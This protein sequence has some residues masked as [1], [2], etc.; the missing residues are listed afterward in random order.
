VLLA[1]AGAVMSLRRPTP[2]PV[3]PAAPPLVAAAAQPALADL[4]GQK[5][6]AAIAAATK[7]NRPQS[8]ITALTAAKT[9]MVAL[10][11]PMKPG[12]PADAAALEQ[13]NGAARQIFHDE[14]APLVRAEKRL[15]GS[16]STP[17]DTQAAPAAAQ[18]LASFT[19]A[20]TNLD[21]ALAVDES[22]AD[23]AHAIDATAQALASFGALQDAYAVA[24]P[25]Y[26][27]AKRKQF[28]AL[29]A[30]AQATAGQVA[31]LANVSKPWILASR[32]RK[33]AYQTRQDN[34][35]KAKSL[36]APLDTLA[37]TL[38]KIS[39]LKQ[40]DAAIAQVTAAKKSLDGLVAASNAATL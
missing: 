27:G 39:D 35:A 24:A 31:T 13:L 15:A 34:A 32:A 16:L 14:S 25:Y 28:A 36:M 8:E 18:S 21:T 26:V 12:K 33:N 29:Y 2:A 3:A 11:A 4:L 20:K 30:D 1:G 22:K 19:Q 38:A 17:L 9:S 37:P 5:L 10:A 6:D 23:A 7:A 40:L